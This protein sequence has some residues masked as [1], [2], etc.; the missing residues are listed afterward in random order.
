VYR[1]DFE[2]ERKSREELN[3][4]RLKLQEKLTA[5]EE[6]LHA[7]KRGGYHGYAAAQRSGG[8]AE[9]MPMG[10]VYQQQRIAQ[11]Q[12]APQGA[13]AA[14]TPTP[15]M[16]PAETQPANRANQEVSLTSGSWITFL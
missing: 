7:V 3:D 8:M 6:E 4:Q 12:L 2:A 16:A 13:A 10:D 9:G 5:M 15:T 11:E 1:I 14:A